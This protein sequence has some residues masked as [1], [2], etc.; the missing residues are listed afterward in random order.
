[1]TLMCPVEASMPKSA[2]LLAWGAYLCCCKRT[3][4]S[5]LLPAPEQCNA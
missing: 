5:V 3:G 1:M 4:L 2:G